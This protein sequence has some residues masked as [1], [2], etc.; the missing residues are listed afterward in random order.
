MI[1]R[2]S[3]IGMAL[4]CALAL[5]IAA[6]SSASAA[7]GRAF[8]CVKGKGTLRG[9]HCLTEG[10]AAAEFGH[11]EIKAGVAT[12]ITATNAKSA[13]S[14]T[15]SSPAV[16]SG[17]LAGIE[18]EINCTTVSGTGELTNAA[19]SV[20]GNGVITYTGCTVVK[21]ARECKV[22]EGKVVTKKLTATTVGLTNANELKFEGEVNAKGE[23]IFAEV[24][25]EGCKENKPAAAAYPVTGSL[26]ATTNGA[27]TETT[28]AG[29][30]AQK[31]LLFGGQLAG[32]GGAITISTSKGVPLAL[33]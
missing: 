10:T 23:K 3:V 11:V 25:L 13:S 21:P 7:P 30:K 4:I 19:A 15:A 20:S 2:K 24:N 12:A 31:T 29:V 16:L 33:T 18:T 1:G 14:T 6:V 32:L 27:T 28:V 8:E 5:S 17:T 26:I 22:K 9:E